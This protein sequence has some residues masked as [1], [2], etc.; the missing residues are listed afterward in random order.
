LILIYDTN[1]K[2]AENPSIEYDGYTS[3]SLPC[4]H[5]REIGKKNI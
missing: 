5:L 4:V 2:Q 1:L 3:K